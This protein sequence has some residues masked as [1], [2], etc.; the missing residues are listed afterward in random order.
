MLSS[1]G[2]SEQDTAVEN[3]MSTSP[4][5]AQKQFI[6]RQKNKVLMN[7]SSSL[8][9]AFSSG[10]GNEATRYQPAELKHLQPLTY[11]KFTGVNFP[12]ITRVY[13]P[14]L[15]FSTQCHIFHP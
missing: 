10:R 11:S 14:I 7:Y 3:S 2:T 8:P 1:P 6:R 4:C 13:P 5:G 15:E 9:Q 12:G